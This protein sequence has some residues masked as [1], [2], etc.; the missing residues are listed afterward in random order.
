MSTELEFLDAHW[1]EAIASYLQ[2]LCVAS[3]TSAM[4]GIAGRFTQD[5]AFFCAFLHCMNTTDTVSA[6]TI[7]YSH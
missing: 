5:D 6:V 3:N 2:Q 7:S 4:D 1:D